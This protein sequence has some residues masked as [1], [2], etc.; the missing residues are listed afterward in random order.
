MAHWMN[1]Q[2]LKGKR[3]WLG[4]KAVAALQAL[5]PQYGSKGMDRLPRTYRCLKGWRRLKPGQSKCPWAWPV[6]FGVAM[7]LWRRGLKRMAVG[8]LLQV[9]CYLRVTELLKLTVGQIVAPTTQGVPH[10]SLSVFPAERGD[11]S[12]QHRGTKE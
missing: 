12:K 4:E 10:W 8:I 7:Q 11:M 9:A 1:T 6:W 5:A 2:F 3:P